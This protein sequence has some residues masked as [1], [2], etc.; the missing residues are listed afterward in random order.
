MRDLASA[1]EASGKWH[2]RVTAYSRP[3]GHSE[4]GWAV[5]ISLEEACDLGLRY[6][7]DAIYFID[8][9]IL[10]AS[11]C[12]PQ[13]RE[14]FQIGASFRDRLDDGFRTNNPS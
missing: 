5:E 2:H 12:E 9:D 10:L 3:T 6:Q 7:Q 8:G 14:L 1:R 13:Q 4:A 11:R